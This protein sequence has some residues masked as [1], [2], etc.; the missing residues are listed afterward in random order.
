MVIYHG[1][2]QIV[3]VPTYGM[4]KV[5]NDY[6]RGFYCT[7]SL[8]LA[9]EWACP[10]DKDGY[11]NKYSLD[12]EDLSVLYL[13]SNE[14]HILNWLALLLKNRQISLGQ[15]KRIGLQGRDYLIENFA[16]DI[17]GYDVI[18]GYRAD[19]RYFAFAKDFVQNGIS[20]SQL[21]FAM[22]LGELGEQVV[23]ISPKAFRKIHF[24]GFEVS[25]GSIYYR[26]RIEREKRA[27]EAFNRMHQDELTDINGLFM[28]DIIREGVKN[29]DPRL[30]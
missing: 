6:G 11:A 5:D 21:S 19:D 23:L 28:R 14:Y 1:S 22:K 2:Q 8:E 10:L 24:E 29:D 12:L 26:K 18:V 7:E 4:G 9:K 15:N 27:N 3:Q 30:R 16:P 13:N 20:I 17:T 25:D